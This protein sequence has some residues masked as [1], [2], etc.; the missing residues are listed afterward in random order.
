MKEG[1]FTALLQYI[2]LY[3]GEFLEI[4]IFGL[5]MFYILGEKGHA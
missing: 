1:G 5:R 3:A 2:R 4:L